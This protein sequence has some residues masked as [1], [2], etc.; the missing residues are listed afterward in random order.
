[1]TSKY[2]GE[3][4][5]ADNCPTLIS[6]YRQKCRK[7]KTSIKGKEVLLLLYSLLLWKGWAMVFRAGN[8]KQIR[9]GFV[10]ISNILMLRC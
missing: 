9:N 1:M 5:K 4:R 2:A 8:T 7:S 3:K 10:I 6:R